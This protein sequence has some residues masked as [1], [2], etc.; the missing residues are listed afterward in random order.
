MVGMK[1]VLSGTSTS[2]MKWR[3]FEMSLAYGTATQ[4]NVSSCVCIREH[5]VEEL[6]EDEEIQS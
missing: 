3:T 1:P 2:N 5:T 6:S 4:H